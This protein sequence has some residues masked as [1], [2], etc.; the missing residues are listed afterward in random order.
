MGRLDD[1]EVVREQYATERNLA[2]RKSIYGN[3]DGPDARDLAFQAV[4]AAKPRRVLEVGGGEGE[5]AAR[6]VHELGAE[7]VGI[8]QSERMVQIQRG[9]GLDARVGDVQELPFADGQF[10]ASL[11]AWMLYHVPDPHRALAELAR[12]LRPGG[13]LVA[14]ATAYEHLAELSDLMGRDRSE[15]LRVFG[16]QTGEEWLR[17]SFAHVERRDLDGWITMD[18]DAVR[19]YVSSWPALGSEREVPPLDQPLRVRTAGVIFVA[20]TAQ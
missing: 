20:E 12:V 18:E 1:P 10:D 13:R 7:L 19:R 2:L 15:R 5:L 4:A 9:K 11:A 6:I 14:V 8:D 3:S 16:R 17:R